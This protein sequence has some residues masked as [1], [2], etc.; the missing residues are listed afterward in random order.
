MN[1]SDAK[2]IAKTITFDQLSEM[3]E[4]AKNNIKDWS[5]ISNVNRC[6]TVGKVWNMLYPS[7]TLIVMR[8]PPALKNMIWEFGDYLP[9][10]LKI[11]KPVKKPY[12]GKVLHEEPVFILNNQDKN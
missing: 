4:T 8:C 7:L 6:L 2:K 12:T 1:Q 9:E 11:K 10:E 3:F 5:E